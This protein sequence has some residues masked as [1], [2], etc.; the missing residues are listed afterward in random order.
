[1]IIEAHPDALQL[2][3]DQGWDKMPGVEI[4]GCKWE[5]AINDPSLGTFDAVY[6][7]T[8]SQDY[9]GELRFS[10]TG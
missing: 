10:L 7:D 1:M 9:Q 4:F 3:R 8:Y 2:M 6:F 5:E